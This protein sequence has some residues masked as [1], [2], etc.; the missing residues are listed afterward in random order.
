MLAR[1]RVL[2]EEALYTRG[3]QAFASRTMKMRSSATGT[4][5]RQHPTRGKSSASSDVE[6]E[7][8]RADLEAMPEG[9]RQQLLAFIEERMGLAKGKAKATPLDRDQI[10]ALLREISFHEWGQRLRALLDCL[11]YTEEDNAPTRQRFLE[12]LPESG[13]A[14]LDR[15]I[16]TLN[17]L[18]ANVAHI[19][20]AQLCCFQRRKA[21]YIADPRTR[22]HLRD[23]LPGIERAGENE[24]PLWG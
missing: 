19:P 7:L 23:L 10:A 20:D 17:R 4:G 9:L 5:Q 1:L 14:E 24:E 8:T 22:H 21:T 3:E 2:A 15:Y 16:A 6:L 18:A 13:R 11:A 12:S